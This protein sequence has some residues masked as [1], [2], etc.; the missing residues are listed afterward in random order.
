MIKM[1]LSIPLRESWILFS[2]SY[3]LT[4][5]SISS[6]IYYRRDAF[7]AFQQKLFDKR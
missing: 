4:C 3:I 2:I 6:W 5:I 1:N 7:G